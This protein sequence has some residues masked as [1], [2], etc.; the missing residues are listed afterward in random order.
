MSRFN[1]RLA[2]M[3]DA[4]RALPDGEEV[5]RGLMRLAA[6]VDDYLEQQTAQR[7]RNG[8]DLFQKWNDFLNQAVVD[9]DQYH[10][11]QLVNVRRTCARVVA[12]D[13]RWHGGYA[14]ALSLLEKE[15]SE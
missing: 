9:R 6:D 5:A 7:Y 1:E 4:A 15:Q 10:Q 8:A 12:T 3:A 11:Q 2:L 14:N 13:P